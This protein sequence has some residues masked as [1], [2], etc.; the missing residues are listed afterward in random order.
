MKMCQA[1]SGIG[2]EVYLIGPNVLEEEDQKIFDFYDVTGEFEIIET[3]NPKLRVVGKLTNSFISVRKVIDMDLDLIH[4][5]N[6]I[7]AYIASKKGLPTIYESHTPIPFSNWSF[8]KDIFFR[9]LLNY[10]DFLQLVVIS[11]S[12]KDYYLDN[13]DLSSKCITLARDA[14]DPVDLSLKPVRYSN[15]K[16]LQVGYIGNIYQG[17][18]KKVI[19]YLAKECD[20]AHFH[21]V[22]GDEDNIIN[23][24]KEL[25]FDNVTFHGF[26]PPSDLDRYKLG[27]DVLLAPYQR[28]VK[29]AGGKN[30][31]KWMSPLKI[32]EYMAAGKAIIASDLPAIREILSDEE[33]ALLCNP[34][35]LDE[36]LKSLKNLRDAS[37]REKLGENALTKFAEKYSWENRAQKIMG[38]IPE[39]F[40]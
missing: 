11:E 37:L 35:K 3:D 40:N 27:F 39:K 32:F 10:K 21:I 30:T 14:S 7:T 8:I 16:S 17:R 9:K 22:G 19:K 25:E 34:E 18:G 38:K 23:W 13:Y 12:M 36:W 2:H 15:D 6:V 4:T 26:V 31:V 5:R 33:N 20:F 1:L 29:T 24:K 28:N